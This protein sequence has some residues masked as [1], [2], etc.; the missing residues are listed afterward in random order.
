MR[1]PGFTDFVLAAMLVAGSGSLVAC[2][3]HTANQADCLAILHRLVELELTESGFRDRK[4][5]DRWTDEISRKFSAD[6]SRCQ[7]RRV[8]DDLAACLNRARTQEE[9]AHG[10]LR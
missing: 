9:I 2:Q 4:V 7:G 5:R 6:L 1:V 8:P 10:C 3:R